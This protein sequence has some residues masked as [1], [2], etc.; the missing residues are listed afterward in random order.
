MHIL[1]KINPNN[2]VEE[3]LNL[4]DSS[5]SLNEQELIGKFNLSANWKLG[6]SEALFG[7][8]FRKNC[9]HVGFIFDSQRDAFIWPKRHQS[10]TLNEETCDWNPPTPRPEG[11]NYFWNEETKN[12]EESA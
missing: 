7:V 6:D 11:H 8:G 12:W 2:V 10:W 3:I 1:A 4:D 5:Q 9:P